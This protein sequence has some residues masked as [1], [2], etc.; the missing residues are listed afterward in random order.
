MSALIQQDLYVDTFCDIVVGLLVQSA[1]ATMVGLTV[2]SAQLTVR[3]TPQD[4]SP[5]L[6][7]TTAAGQLTFGVAPPPPVGAQCA[8]V[9]ELEAAAPLTVITTPPEPTVETFASLAAM[10]AFNA[11]ALTVGQLAIVT[12][13][14]G[15]FYQWSPGDTNT[16]NGTT[17]VASTG[18][19]AGN[20]L[21]A[22]T[23]QIQVAQALLLPLL[24][25]SQ[26]QYD[27]LVT[28]SN[29]TTTKLLEGAWYT[30][31]TVGGH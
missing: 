16:P 28:W 15:S 20:W 10:A 21:L 9:S 14:V 7:A 1:G 6:V 25:T 3:V 11:S 12:A 29:G 31:Q 8:N 2:T 5:L 27:L 30:D 13:G 17:I 18:G 4:V 24:G 19:T 26:A 22:V 23:V